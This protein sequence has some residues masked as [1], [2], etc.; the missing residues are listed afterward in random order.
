L[1]SNTNKTLSISPGFVDIHSVFGR[2][3]SLTPFLELAYALKYPEHNGRTDGPEPWSL[4]QMG[5]YQ[6]YNYDKKQ[7][8]WIL[9]H[10]HAESVAWQML[11]RL[12]CG[13]MQSTCPHHRL[14]VI[15]DAILSS[16]IGNWKPFLLYYEEQVSKMVCCND[17]V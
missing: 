3:S 13:D 2:C 10:S 17:Q 1:R 6:Q 14:S 9:L 15:H 11:K 7:T 16:Y 4:R 8:T 5:V 12:T